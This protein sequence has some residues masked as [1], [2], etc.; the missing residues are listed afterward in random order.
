[1]ESILNW[2]KQLQA[3]AQTGKTFSKDKF[4][5]ERFE[6]DCR[7]FTPDVL[8][9]KWGSYRTDSSNYSCLKKGILL[10][11]LICELALLRRGKSF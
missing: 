3:I 10:R 9:Y 8:T 7:Y 6:A 1:M 5:L 2:A 11:K 4:D